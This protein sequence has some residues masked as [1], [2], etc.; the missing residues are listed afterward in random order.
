MTTAERI[1]FECPTC[2]L[3]TN[4]PSTTRRL[5]CRCGFDTVTGP[6]E[7]AES[8]FLWARIRRCEACDQYM[9]G[10]R[11]KLIHLGCRNEFRAVA[12]HAT[13]CCPRAY[14]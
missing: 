12:Y 1:I 11:C 5:I 4:V 14:W 9:G 6:S 3:I 10:E 13:G 2:G 7:M 8:H